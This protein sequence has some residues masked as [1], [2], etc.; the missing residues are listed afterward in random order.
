MLT[1]RHI[2]PSGHETILQTKRVTSQPADQIHGGERIIFYEKD[3]GSTLPIESGAVYVMNDNG[4]TVATY[5][6]D[7]LVPRNLPVDH[8]DAQR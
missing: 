1:I 4:K 5:H 6:L 8:H 7:N 3:D 2:E